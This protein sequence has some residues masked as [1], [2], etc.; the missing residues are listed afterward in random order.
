MTHRE[1]LE[2]L[3]WYATLNE[4]RRRALDAHL[5]GCTECVRELEEIRALQTAIAPLETTPETSPFLLQRTLAKIDA[6]DDERMSPP[7]GWRRVIAWW[8]PSPL[9]ARVLIAAQAGLLVVLLAATAYFHHQAQGFSTL[10]GQ[11]PATASGPRFTIAFQPDTSEETLRET[12]R[13]A[14]GTIVEGPSALGLYT[15]QIPAKSNPDEVLS[16]LRARS[17]VVRYAEKKPE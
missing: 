3:P 9:A 12:I 15:V 7:A 10:S 11:G 13:E 8:S 14:N 1:S 6:F 4:E 5:E 17:D 2:L 16:Q